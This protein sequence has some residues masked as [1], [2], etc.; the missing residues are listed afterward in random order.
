MKYNIL[1]SVHGF[2]QTVVCYY[3]T[4]FYS[5]W[6]RVNFMDLVLPN[7]FRLLNIISEYH[8]YGSCAKRRDNVGWLDGAKY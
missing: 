7:I 2:G 3:F 1:Q 5:S 8:K 6:Q 4:L